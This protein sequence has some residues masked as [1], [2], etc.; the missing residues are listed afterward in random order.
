[1]VIFLEKEL[2]ARILHT[3]LV[4]TFHAASS[5]AFLVTGRS[6][7]CP[8]QPKSSDPAP[9]VVTCPFTHPCRPAMHILVAVDPAFPQPPGSWPDTEDG[10]PGPLLCGDHSGMTA[11]TLQ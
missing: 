7:H 1:M 10:I 5:S 6:H 3:Q 11:S 8:S 2:Y 4:G 9:A